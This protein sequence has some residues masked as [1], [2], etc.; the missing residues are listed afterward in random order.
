MAGE[1]FNPLVFSHRMVLKNFS[2]C[3]D[4]SIP[5]SRF[6]PQRREQKMWDGREKRDLLAVPLL[7]LHGGKNCR[8]ENETLFLGSASSSSLGW[9]CV[10]GDGASRCWVRFFAS[11]RRTNFCLARSKTNKKKERRRKKRKFEQIGISL[12]NT[13]F[14]S[15]AFHWSTT[16]PKSRYKAP[17]VKVNSVDLTLMTKMDVHWPRRFV[18]YRLYCTPIS[19]G[20]QTPAYL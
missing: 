13:T 5:S 12:L 15:A 10:L 17:Q 4:F 6:S 7:L 14:L 20:V 8:R 19:L 3:W 9:V 16:T 18:K 2:S 11:L 1:V